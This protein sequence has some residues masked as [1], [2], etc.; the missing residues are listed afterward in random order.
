MTLGANLPPMDSTSSSPTPPK[1]EPMREPSPEREPEEEES[2]VELDNEGVI[3]PETVVP[4]EFGDPNKCVS[5]DDMDASQEKRSEAMAAMSDGD[6]QKAVD[7]FTEAI[8]LNPESGLLYAK[9]ASI[10]IK[11]K[12]V[13]AAIR[14]CDEALKHNPDSATAFKFRGRAHRWVLHALLAAFHS[15][16]L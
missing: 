3:V 11:Q 7:L 12:R 8:K 5:E 6:L 10:L 14:D 16:T 2:E 13:K 15:H 1:D 4:P 9:R